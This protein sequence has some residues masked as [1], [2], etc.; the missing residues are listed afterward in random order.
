MQRLY[1]RFLSVWLRS[2]SQMWRGAVPLDTS[3]R[4]KNVECLQQIHRMMRSGQREADGH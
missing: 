1:D 3:Q 4:N 2:A